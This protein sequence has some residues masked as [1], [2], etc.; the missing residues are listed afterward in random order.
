MHIPH[1]F[2][3]HSY[4]LFN[5][6]AGTPSTSI[7][8]FLQVMRVFS[9][10]SSSFFFFFALAFATLGRSKHTGAVLTNAWQVNIA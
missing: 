2:S 3:K 6:P 9:N 8:L 7:L 10:Q 5:K 4:L 1:A